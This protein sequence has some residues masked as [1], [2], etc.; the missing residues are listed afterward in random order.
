MKRFY[1][2]AA[3]APVAG[4][5]T[6]ALDGKPVRTPAK[7]PLI[8]PSRTLADAIA[9][10]WQRQG[11]AVVTA[12][13][14]LTGLTGAAIDLVAARRPE[15]VA[16]IANFAGTD[17]VC[18][19][20]EHPPALVARQHEAWQP[21]IDWT[22]QRYDAPLM[23]TSGVTPVAQPE[24][25][26]RVLRHAVDAYDEF[27]LAALHLATAACGS[28]VVALALVE[29]RIDADTAFEV[30][31]LDESFEIEHWGE[32]SEQT[33]RRALLKDD[34]ALAARFVALLRSPVAAPPLRQ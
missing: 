8:V 26:L 34:I 4:G 21:L 7:T 27:T 29:S 18:Y 5:F 25:S 23:V 11:D 30:S 6:V 32:D 3:A 15:I 1:K 31:Q 20:A 16:Q 14:P 17:L 13:L 12:L 33:K 9:E 22:T 10:E 24:P 28:L 19:R 2:N